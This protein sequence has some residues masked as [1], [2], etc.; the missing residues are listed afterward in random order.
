MSRAMKTLAVLVVIATLVAGTV[1]LVRLS[2]GDFSGDYR[3]TGYFS[4]SGEGLQPGSLVVY[5]GVQVGR[6]SAID[7]AGTSAKVS[8]LVQ[9]T[10]RASRD[11]TATIEPVNLFGAEQVSINDPAGPRGVLPPGGTFTH[12]AVSAVLGNL[13]AA[14]TPLLRRI[15]T[16]DLASVINDLAQASN[17]EGPRIATALGE[18]AKLAALLDNTLQAQLAALDAFATFTGQ[19]APDTGAINGL[20]AEENAGLPSFNAAAADYQKLLESLTP[21]SQDLA[22]L[23]ADYRPDIDTLLADGDNVA[24]VLTAQSSDVGNLLQGLYQYVYKL[25][26]V[27][28]SG[29]LPDGSRFAYF[30]TFILFSDVNQLVCSLLAPAQ[31]GLSFLEPLQQSLAG[32][33]SAF[34]C[35]S[36]LAAFD[37]AQGTSTPVAPAVAPAPAPTTVPASAASSPTPGAAQALQQLSQQVYAALGQAAAP[38]SGSIGSYV[39]SLLGGGE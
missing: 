7:L 1:T 18:G 11:A 31:S 9:P 39:H 17:G 8:V 19:V 28:S 29:T 4:S 30:N 25:G 12:T 14:A 32:A 20:S 26:H 38:V 27:G 13:F 37:A 6:V 23:L 24:R 21:F 22:T 36:E 10:F 15:D 5:R 33:G 16:T 35:S 2:N 3:L 34:N